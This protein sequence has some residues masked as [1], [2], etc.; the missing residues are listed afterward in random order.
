MAHMQ[1]EHRMHS[2][3]LAIYSIKIPVKEYGNTE[4]IEA[5]KTEIG[6]LIEFFLH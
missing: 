5:K 1:I 6:N 4:V 2:D 3:E